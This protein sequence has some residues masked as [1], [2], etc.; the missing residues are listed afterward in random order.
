MAFFLIK[1]VICQVSPWNAI[2]DWSFDRDG[3]VFLLVLLS[4]S[5]VMFD[6]LF[7][8]FGQFSNFV[9]PILVIWHGFQNMRLEIAREWPDGQWSLL[10]HHLVDRGFHFFVK[11]GKVGF[12]VQIVFFSNRISLI[13]GSLGHLLTIRINFWV[14]GCLIDQEWHVRATRLLKRSD[15]VSISLK[16]RTWW[17]DCHDGC[18]VTIQKGLS[19][20]LGS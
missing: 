18:S 9:E 8:F 17:L 13:V 11:G 6:L 2:L 7:V 1:S 20:I 19:A 12:R 16:G 14:L 15:S 3:L 10:F 5:L 4:Q